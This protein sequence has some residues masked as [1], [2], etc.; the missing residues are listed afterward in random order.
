MA[1]TSQGGGVDV[2]GAAYGSARVPLL[3]VIGVD[4]R[5]QNPFVFKHLVSE[6]MTLQTGDY[7]IRGFESS[8]M[9]E[10]KADDMLQ[11]LTTERKRFDRELERAKGFEFSRLLWVCS[12][13][14]LDYLLHRSKISP[15]SLWGS[16]AAID[17]RVMPVVRVD[18]PEQAAELVEGWA[19]YFWAGKVKPFLKLSVPEWARDVAKRSLFKK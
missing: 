12:E 5:E 1:A 15:A 2:S 19:V 8:F 17:A 16:L 13:E 3:P 11:S 4:C 9:V 7:T 14:R 6:Q 18:T 10:R